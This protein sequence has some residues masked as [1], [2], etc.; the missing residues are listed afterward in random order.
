[1]LSSPILFLNCFGPLKTY[2]LKFNNVLHNFLI[3]H[4]PSILIN[5]MPLFI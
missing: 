1:M 5:D 4:R 2:G 3:C